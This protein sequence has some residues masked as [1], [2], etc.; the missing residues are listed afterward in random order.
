MPREDDEPV[1]TGAQ[2][3]SRQCPAA[4]LNQLHGSSQLAPGRLGLE[5]PWRGVAAK[6]GN[7]GIKLR[8][9]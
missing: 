4:G 5:R 3:A 7:E 2:G 1:G 6:T 9:R 8:L